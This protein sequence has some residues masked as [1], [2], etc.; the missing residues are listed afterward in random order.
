MPRNKL[1]TT[2]KDSIFLKRKKGLRRINLRV[3][4]DGVHLSY[5]WHC[6][7]QEAL[8][9]AHTKKDWIRK[10]QET[11]KLKIESNTIQPGYDFKTPSYNLIF[12]HDVLPKFEVTEN[13]IIVYYDSI[14]NLR[15]QEYQK[16]LK[17]TLNEI[18][19]REAKVHLTPLVKE[20]SER[21]NLALNNLTF[22]LAKTRWGSCSHINNI[23]L[24]INLVRQRQDLIEYVIVHELCHTKIKNHSA[25]FWDFLTS[26]IPNARALDRE[27]KKTKCYL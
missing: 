4:D 27:I 21:Y 15:S 20:L 7:E 23:S 6:S 18:T 12:K 5:P 26:F 16:R 14:E 25:T 8:R 2:L 10:Q 19:R 1:N 11:L 13:E 24:N 3:K 22:R 17:K 9:F